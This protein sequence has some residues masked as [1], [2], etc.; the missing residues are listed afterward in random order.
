MGYPPN[1]CTVFDRGPTNRWRWAFIRR[2]KL[3]NGTQIMR[4]PQAR[5]SSKTHGWTMYKQETPLVRE[6][7]RQGVALQQQLR[8]LKEEWKIKNKATIDN[9]LRIRALK[10]ELKALEEERKKCHHHGGSSDHGER[11]WN[12]H[13]WN[14]V[15]RE[16]EL[17]MLKIKKKE[18]SQIKWE[19]KRNW[20]NKE[21]TKI[22][23]EENKNNHCHEGTEPILVVGK[24]GTGKHLPYEKYIRYLPVLNV[25]LTWIG[26]VWL[27]ENL[28]VKERMNPF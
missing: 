28:P 12:D 21:N 18:N 23:K 14:A 5:R 15:I 19:N 8:S 4:T 27:R 13:V 24:Y 10:A 16:D 9:G 3:S 6:L 7:H 1:V 26:P 22:Q 2:L 20:W 25:T 11:K 17:N